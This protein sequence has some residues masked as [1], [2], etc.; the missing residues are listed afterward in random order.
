MNDTHSRVKED[1]AI[2][3][4]VNKQFKMPKSI[5]E[6]EEVT[7]EMTEIGGR[8]KLIK[9]RSAYQARLDDD[10]MYAESEDGKKENKEKETKSEGQAKEEKKE[11]KGS[12]SPSSS[13]S[14]AN[15]EEEEEE[16]EAEEFNPTAEV[17]LR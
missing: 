15:E 9:K 5:R 17:C 1:E 16:G 14:T 11:G 2:A 10:E 12:K 3:K 13:E 7:I 4:A 6:G 8:R